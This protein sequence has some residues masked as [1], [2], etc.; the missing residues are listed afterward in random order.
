MITF[1]IL[2]KNKPLRNI[3]LCFDIK[4]KTLAKQPKF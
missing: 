2:S 3:I 4:I 1:F